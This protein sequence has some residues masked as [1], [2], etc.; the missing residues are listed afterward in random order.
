MPLP[1]GFAERGAALDRWAAL[2][3]QAR[4]ELVE[5]M[6]VDIGKPVR[7]GAAEIDRTLRLNRAAA[8]AP[9]GDLEHPEG[10][11]R[12]RPVGTI[13]VITAFNNPVAVPVGKI[14]PA[15]Y[16]GN[17]V[18]WKPAPAGSAIAA[19]LAELAQ[20]AGAPLEVVYGDASAAVGLAS[21]SGV[22]AVTLTG[23]STAGS[24]IGAICAGRR[25]PFQAE[26]GGNNASIVWSDADLGRAA[27]L[28][29]EGAFGNAG[30]RCTA[31]RRVIVEESCAGAF[32]G[33]LVE[34]TG[35][36]KVGLPLDPEVTV[37]PLVSAAALDRVAA[38]VEDAR[39]HAWRVESPGAIDGLEG[40]F[41]PPTIVCT[42][43]AGSEIVQ[44]ETFGPVL[45]VQRAAS[46][47]QAIELNNGVAQ[48]LVAAVFTHDAGRKEQFLRGAQAGILKINRSTVDAG[49]EVPFGGWKASGFG[50]PEHGPGNLAFYTR[51]QT[52]YSSDEEA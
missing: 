42:D 8:H 11:V 10:S 34:A 35:R 30:Q 14:A 23:G 18:V 13:A 51:T 24:T 25:I 45:V 33:L 29:A 16:Y 39:S 49:V 21:E 2:I 28:I 31:N 1:G 41:Y 46:F 17:A 7:Y 9:T 47:D 37:G 40:A 22:D 15:L 3:D 27:E 32:I 38:V 48:G 52:V 26:L 4:E 19:R 50:P 43:D 12:R 20:E 36:L 5:K 6:A 44:E